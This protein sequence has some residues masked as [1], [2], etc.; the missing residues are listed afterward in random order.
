MSKQIEV[1]DE[2]WEKIKG[3]VQKDTESFE[4]N[5]LDDLI[6]K[7]WFIRTVTYHL[8]GKVKSRIGNFLLLIDAAWIADSGRFM[9]AIKNGTLNEVEPVG[10]AMVNINSVVDMFPWKFNLPKEQK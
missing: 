7:K 9:E 5:D 1:S 2:T 6:G 4:L 3:L 10:D 8:T